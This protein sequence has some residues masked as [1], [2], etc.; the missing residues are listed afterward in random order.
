MLSVTLLGL[1]IGITQ[2][3]YHTSYDEAYERAVKEKK[4]LVIYFRADDRHDDVL[5]NKDVKRRLNNYVVLRVPASY[6]YK[7]KRL[8]AYDALEDMGGAAGLAVVSLHNEKLPTHNQVISAHPFVRSHYSWAPD[9]GSREVSGIL[10]LPATAT[11]TQRR[12]IYAVS[13]HPEQPR[14]VLGKA[15]SAFLNHAERHSARQASMRN[16]HHADL[17]GTIGRIQGES[18]V[19]LS[20]GSEV[21]A[22]SWGTFVG[23]ETVLEASFSC[24]DA[25]RHS[26]GHWGAVSR[27]HSYFGYDIARGSNGTWYATGIFA[28]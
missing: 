7:G 19:P 5:L 8:L 16:Q 15:F 18:G 9:Y 28:E 1:V 25:W 3:A 22:E 11:L 17:I 10:D 23:G 4:D 2:P 12:M 14:S 26:P 24:V 21:V 27:E 13:I 6:E 20:G